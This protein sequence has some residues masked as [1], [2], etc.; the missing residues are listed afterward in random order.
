MPPWTNFSGRTACRPR[1]S[2]IGGASCRDG[3]Q[4]CALPISYP[5]IPP[6]LKILAQ[7]LRRH[8]ERCLP[9][10]TSPVGPPAAHVCQRS[11]ERLVGMEFRRVLFRSRT[12]K[13]LH[14][15]R[16]SPNYYEDILSDASLDEL[17]RSDRLPPTSVKDRRSV[18]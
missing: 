12:R 4:T 1:L 18:L 6:H 10:R 8:F 14:I 9:G 7:L 5:K 3:V 15:S 17:L 2:K 13:Y 11:E 16:S